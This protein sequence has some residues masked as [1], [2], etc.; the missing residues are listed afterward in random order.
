MADS[1]VSAMSQFKDACLELEKR[2]V[3]CVGLIE[4]IVMAVL[5][6]FLF[7]W[8]PIL[9]ESTPGEINVGFIFTCMVLT[10]ILGTKI[11]EM[12]ILHLGCDYY[13]F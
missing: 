11:Y 7:S 12:V 6:I 8:T 9:K 5:N 10:M 13:V 2:E 1:K 3:L 4:S